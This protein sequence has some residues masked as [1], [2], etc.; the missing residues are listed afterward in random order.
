MAPPLR[1]CAIIEARMTSTRLPGKVLLPAVGKPMLELMVERL[2]RVPS[3]AGIV[4]ATTVNA[5]DD[6][7]EALARR[8]GVD[9]YRGSE[10]DVLTRVL[11]ASRAHEVDVIVE[12]TGDCPLI[13]PG[14]VEDVIAR[15]RESGVDYVSNFLEGRRYPLGMETQAFAT[16]IL[17]DV[18]RRSDDPVDHEHVSLFIYRNPQLYSLADC[19]PRPALADPGLRLT[20]DTVEDYTLISAVFEALYPA[21]GPAFT[22]ADI[23]RFLDGRPDLRAVNSMVR[24]RYV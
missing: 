2:R 12:I 13:D 6:P 23:L 18:A 7:V 19:P 14:V 21:A 4:I 22:L 17:E 5:T 20:L 9:C 15:Y 1:F 24:Q 10:E 8:L 16:T 11:E 3:L